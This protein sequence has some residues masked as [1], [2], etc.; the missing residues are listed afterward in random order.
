MAPPAA[1]DPIG[2]AALRPAPGVRR[3]DVTAISCWSSTTTTK[4]SSRAEEEATSRGLPTRRPRSR[5]LQ[6]ISFFREESAAFL[7][8]RKVPRLPHFW[9]GFSAGPAAPVGRR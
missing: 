9:T 1:P 4:G 3:S 2:W 7:S 5:A 6:N 8:G